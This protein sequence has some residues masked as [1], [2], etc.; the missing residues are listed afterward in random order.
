MMGTGVTFM[1]ASA[2]RRLLR[3]PVFTGSIAIVVGY[4]EA[5]VSGQPRHGDTSF[6]KLLTR[7]Q[8]ESLVMGKARAA[9]RMEQRRAAFWN[10]NLVGNAPLGQVRA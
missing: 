6:R 9:R 10:P 8:W 5:L 1:L 2:A 4:L 7:Y 3:Y